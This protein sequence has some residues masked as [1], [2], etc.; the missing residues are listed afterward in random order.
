MNHNNFLRLRSDGTRFIEYQAFI[1][2]SKNN[3]RATPIPIIA[4]ITAETPS[5]IHPQRPIGGSPRNG[6]N[7]AHHENNAPTINP[8]MIRTAPMTLL[9]PEPKYAVNIPAMIL[10]RANTNKNMLSIK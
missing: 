1:I 4:P 2:A 5:N 6:R 8:I 3:P 9:F 7:Q 10:A